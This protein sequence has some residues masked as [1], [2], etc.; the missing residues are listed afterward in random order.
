[1][2][3]DLPDQSVFQVSYLDDKELL[4]EFVEGFTLGYR[5]GWGIST[6][7]ALLLLPTSFLL[8]GRHG[9]LLKPMQHANIYV[10]VAAWKYHL[11]YNTKTDHCFSKHF[12]SIKHVFLSLQRMAEMEKDRYWQM[13]K[14]T[15]LIF[16]DM[17]PLIGILFSDDGLKRK[18]TLV[19][20]SLNNLEKCFSQLIMK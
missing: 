7:L 15:V 12:R 20:Y 3:I 10:R 18:F 1:M 4:A 17:T 9:G 14:A 13:N 16:T 8:F 19:K 6:L 5:H 11:A 2:N